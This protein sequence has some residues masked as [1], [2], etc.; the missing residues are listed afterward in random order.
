MI[1]LKMYKD[2]LEKMVLL[3]KAHKV[4]ALPTESVYGLSTILEADAVAKIVTLKKRSANKGF[5]V[6]S[7]NIEHL[8]RVIDVTDLTDEHLAKL[9]KTYDRAT[10]WVVP[11]KPE[12]RWLTGPFESIAV[13]LSMHPLL[14]ELTNMLDQ[15]IVSTS[16]NVSNMPAAT[17]AGEVYNYFDDKVDYIYP[18]DDFVATKPSKLIDL[19]TGE[20]LRE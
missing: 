19:I 6:L 10:T 1:E 12:F 2:D 20:I 13:R 8:L 14:S 4:L 15:A 5:I 11:V 9:Q 16:A 7:S 18:Q 17:S 3:L